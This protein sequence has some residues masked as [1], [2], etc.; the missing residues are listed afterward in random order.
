MCAHT[1]AYAIFSGYDFPI[2]S[3]HIL[4]LRHWFVRYFFFFTRLLLLFYVYSLI[5]SLSIQF[6]S[7]SL[8][9]FASIVIRVFFGRPCACVW[10]S[11]AV[12]THLC[13]IKCMCVCVFGFCPKTFKWVSMWCLVST[14]LSLTLDAYFSYTSTKYIY[15][16]WF[17]FCF[18]LSTWNRRKRRRRIRH[19]G[20]VYARY[21]LVNRCLYIVTIEWLR[22]S[23]SFSSIKNHTPRKKSKRNHHHHHFSVQSP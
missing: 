20:M 9:L 22:V 17:W 5:H 1:Y 7:F 10:L 13:M 8:A 12:F 16:Y 2:C 3:F 4:C 11:S 6:F 15:L 19:G 23:A 18:D 14:C 21:I